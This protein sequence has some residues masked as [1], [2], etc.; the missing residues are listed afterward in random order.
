MKA[1]RTLMDPEEIRLFR[2]DMNMIRLSHSM[3]RLDMPGYDFDRNELIACIAKLVDI[4]SKWIPPG[5][6][7]S[8]YIRPT[9]IATHRY[10]GLAPPD[11][12]LFYC[13]MT[14]VGPYFKTGFHPIRLTADMPYVR[15]WPGGTGF[16]KVGGNYA[17]TMK[18]QAE[19]AAK[20][21][22]QVLWLFGEN[23]EITEVG[24]MNVFF[25]IRNQITDR[26]E[27][28]T[29]P[30]TRGDILPGVTRDSILH[31]AR[32]QQWDL[33]VSERFATMPEIK[34]A[35]DEGRLIEA[36]GAGTAA[37]VTPIGCIQYQGEDLIIND[38]KP[39]TL[40]QKI[41]DVVTGIQYGKIPG[42][43]GWS[44]NVNDLTLKS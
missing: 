28:I 7:Y 38:N 34:L 17:P 13:I 20:G 36:F 15:A 40:T 21:Y 31:L 6:G 43:P 9:V 42:P 26:A 3:E 24:S 5:E 41:W 33:D 32:Q 1:Y 10:L 37:V 19:A 22:G 35:Y 27:L 11:S 25:V 44:I 8:L 29:A 18:P 14:P 30:L 12:I 2:P 4:D 23:E 16:A 39:G